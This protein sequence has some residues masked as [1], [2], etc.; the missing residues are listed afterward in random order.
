MLEAKRQR[1]L[2]VSWRYVQELACIYR[3]PNL[4]KTPLVLDLLGSISLR[5]GY[6]DDCKC[7]DD[8]GIPSVSRPYVLYLPLAISLS[9][10]HTLSTATI[11][12]LCALMADVLAGLGATAACAGLIGFLTGTVRPIG[13]KMVNDLALETERLLCLGGSQAIYHMPFRAPETC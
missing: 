3:V 10:Q 8:C 1:T 4:Q 2:L 6:V 9:L 5:R 13:G 11:N 12:T 7:C